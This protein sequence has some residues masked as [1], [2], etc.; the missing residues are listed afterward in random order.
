M[1]KPRD[2]QAGVR[3]GDPVL[4]LELRAPLGDEDRS[5]ADEGDP[6][7]AQGVQ[8]FLEDQIGEN[9]DDDV[10]QRQEGI[11]EGQFDLR[12]DVKVRGHRNDEGAQAE[13]DPRIEDD[14]QDLQDGVHAGKRDRRELHHAVF[15]HQLRRGIGEHREQDEGNELRHLLSLE[16]SIRPHAD[17]M[18][19]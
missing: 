7:D 4:A 9:R 14:L 10:G 8:V 1:G 6:A 12:Q 16:P 15:Q 17:R 19:A 11:G 13:E 3:S 18:S 2:G 5:E